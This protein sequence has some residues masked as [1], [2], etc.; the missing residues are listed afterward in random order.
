M[1]NA[2][3]ICRRQA[4][5]NTHTANRHDRS[6]KRR[7]V[8]AVSRHSKT[9]RSRRCITRRGKRMNDAFTA[10]VQGKCTCTATRTGQASPVPN[11]LPPTAAAACMGVGSAPHMRH[12]QGRRAHGSGSHSV[13]VT[14]IKMAWHAS[15]V[16]DQRSRLTTG[17]A[18]VGPSYHFSGSGHPG[19]SV[20]ASPPY[21]TG[22]PA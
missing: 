1:M 6:S 5:G 8:A 11:P 20:P 3:L 18:G 19:I 9:R 14:A 4:G 10:S 21:H 13:V 7:L 12:I 2:A 16:G 15:A 17:E 22:I